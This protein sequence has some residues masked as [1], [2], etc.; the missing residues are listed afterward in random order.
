M[1][2]YMSNPNF[3][4]MFMSAQHIKITTDLINDISQSMIGYT[5]MWYELMG[6][7]LDD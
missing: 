7:T 6:V 1:F 2:G 3:V 5:L 4:G